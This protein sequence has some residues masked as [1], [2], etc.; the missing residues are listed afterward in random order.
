M[1]DINYLT[2]QQEVAS[3]CKLSLSNAAE[4]AMIKRW[5]NI[6]PED[7][8][9]RSDWY[10]LQSRE[11]VQTVIE[12]TAGTIAIAVGGTAVTG[13]GTAFASTDVGSYIQF[14][15]SDDWYKIT[16]VASATG[17][18]IEK[19]VTGTTALTVGTYTIRKVYYSLSSNV[20]KVL[21]LRQS[22]TPVKL[23]IVNYREFDAYRPNVDSPGDPTTCVMF[24]MDSSRNWQ[25]F[26]DPIPDAIM[27]MEFRTKLR[28]TDLSDDADV[29]AI[30][31]K[32]AKTVM[33]AG[34]IWRGMEYSRISHEDKRAD[35]WLGMFERG[36]ERM[37]AGDT[38][39]NDHHT[40][41]KS[42]ESRVRNIEIPF[43]ENYDIS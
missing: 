17:A 6:S 21:D 42:N 18:T 14:S 13:T 5:I 43:P 11:V 41:L 4:L 37:L 1:S 12:K 34:A 28:S 29:S 31:A 40:R 8:N 9:S 10:W 36:I 15:S 20:D 24:G 19:A 32:W 26:L 27:N 33:L 30:P 2:L 25:F 38:V 39:T 23:N 3:M 16:A 35:K 7:V 22:I